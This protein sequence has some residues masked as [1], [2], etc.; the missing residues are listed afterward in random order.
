[1]VQVLPRRLR[2]GGPAQV[3][4]AVGLA[5]V[6]AG[7]GRV[8]DALG[9]IVH[10]GHQLGQG[11]VVDRGDGE[12]GAQGARGADGA[13]VQAP[14]GVVVHGGGREVLAVVAGGDHGEHAGVAGGLDGDRA[15]VGGVLLPV[16][17]AER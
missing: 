5:V 2:R 3:D 10:V 4:Q 9:R 17:G 1:A 11:A 8:R 7:G 15:G 14:V 16:G 12:G 13:V 6:A